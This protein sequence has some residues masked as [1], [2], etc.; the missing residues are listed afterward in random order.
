MFAALALHL[1]LLLAF[2]PLL[3]GVINRV[4]AIYGGRRGA[5]LLQPYYDL[6]RLFRKSFL[7]SKSTSWVFLAGPVVGLGAVLLAGLLVPQG[8]QAA[9]IS[10]TGDIIMLLYLLG[11]ARFFTASAALDTASPFEG[12]GA[13]RE[14]SFSCYAEPALLL[15][16]VALSRLSQSFSMS[17]IFSA[18]HTGPETT[19]IAPLLLIGTSWFVVLLAENCRIPFDDPNTHLE[20]TMVHEVMVLDHSGPPFGMILY[21]AAMKL[22]ISAALVANLLLGR[23]KIVGIPGALMFA[24]VL[25]VIAIVIGLVESSMARLRFLSVPKLLA[26]ACVLSGF[27]A[28]L[29]MR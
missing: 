3:I 18:L 27:G 20:L 29:V 2:P 22:F 25:I 6:W 11:L 13:A 16:F 26:S 8:A 19:L 28:L 1:L 12:M 4:K 5:P 23:S 10:F 14:V 15:G 21:S 17:G 7:V 24:G 9:P